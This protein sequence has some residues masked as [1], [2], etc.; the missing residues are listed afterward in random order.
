MVKSIIKKAKKN[1]KKDTKGHKIN[2]KVSRK[3]KNVVHKPI[4]K[5][6][7]KPIIVKEI[8][9][10]VKIKEQKSKA[11]N[12]SEP[13][14]TINS[15]KQLEEKILEKF[16][17]NKPELN[18]LLDIKEV[19]PVELIEKK[20]TLKKETH[21][22][23]HTD[24]EDLSKEYQARVEAILFAVGKYLDEESISQLCD[25]DKRNTKKALEEIKK[26]YD[27][28]N[29]ALT[30][31]QEGNSWKINVREKYV[32]LV[33]KIVADTEISK[34]IMET[35]AIIAWKTP[36]YQNEVVRIRGNK[37]Y[38][39][40]AELEDAGFITKIKKGRSYILKT[41]DKF[42]TYFDIDQ[43]NLHGIMNEAKIPITQTKLEEEKSEETPYSRE[44]LLQ[45]LE[46]IET[47]S[48]VQTEED[49]IAQKTFLEQIHQKIDAA[50][51]R[52]NEVIAEIPRPMHE[53]AEVQQIP[54]IEEV[55]SESKGNSI[56]KKDE[57]DIVI[58]TD[59]P[60]GSEH[61]FQKPEEQPNKP[62]QLTKK[63]LEKKFKEELQRVKE[64]GEKK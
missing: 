45:A 10:P 35:L 51:K 40:I 11:V 60:N 8:K 5:E 18:A 23:E 7:K 46:T 29:T 54:I 48:I 3:T 47:K 53:Q 1:S 37:C 62:K 42:Y 21:K 61:H 38:D 55:P 6:V 26:D 44:K 58:N 4:K 15:L 30:I 17:E 12:L 13:I 9:S 36:V 31:I 32:S 28:R 16:E 33:R 19:K 2:E 22:K 64:K 41:T 56:V 59:V 39:H 14:S 50:S 27:E 57:E 34:S 24:K 20:E 25:I 52:T 49:K 63:Q 43:K